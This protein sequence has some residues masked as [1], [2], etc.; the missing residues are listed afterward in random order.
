MG[1]AGGS[2]TDPAADPRVAAAPPGAVPELDELAGEWLPAGTLLNLPSVNNF[3][4]GLHAGSNLLSFTE[5]TFPPL[6]LGGECARLTLAGVAVQAH[7]SRW[8]PYQVLRRA[9]QGG[10]VL[11]SA[12]RMG[13]EQQLVLAELSVTN[14]GT[15][16]VQASLAVELGGYLRSYP[17]LW[18]WQVPRQYGDFSGWDG[19]LADGGRVLAVADGGSPAV[20][21]FAFPDPPGQLTASGKAGSASWQLT[22][23]PGQTATLRLVMAAAATAGD[24]VA[25]AAAARD[26]FAGVWA[27]AQTGWQ[28]RFTDAFT[29]GNRHF[30]GSLPVLATS[31]QALRRLY[32]ASVLTVLQLERTCYP[33]YFPRVYTTAGPQWGVTLSY[34]WDTSLFAPL[35]VML[36]PHM[37]REQAKR[38]LELGI[39]RGYAVDVLSGQL[40]GPWY[41]ANDLSVFSMLFDY[42]TV[43]GDVGFL[44]EQAGGTSV[45]DHMQAIALHWQQLEV[46][47]TGLADYGGQANLLEEVANYVNQV[48][49]LNGA[50]VWMMRQLAALRRAR[51]ETGGAQQLLALAGQL[52]PR[53]LAQY[54][55]G[56]GVWRSVHD[57]GSAVPVRHIYD[58][59]T[60]GRLL[61]GDLPA[62][63]R[64]EMASFVAG[65]LLA[66]GWLRA[67]SLSDPDAPA[68]LRPDHGSNGAYDAWP[69]LAAGTLG[70]LGFYQQ[71][72]EF[73]HTFAAVT[74]EGPFA[75]SHELVPEPSGL[76][77]WD[78]DDL[79][80]VAALTVAAWI[81][82]GAWPRQA[83]QGSIVAKDATAG[84]W[85]PTTP[86]NVGYALRGGGNGVISFAVAVGGKFPQA[87]STATVPA[88]SWHHVAGTF[89]GQRITVYI[90]GGQAATA[91]ARGGISPSAG[92]NLLVGADPIDAA[93]KFTGAI[94]EVRVYQRALPAA[95]IAAL[96]TATDAG[97]GSTDP[98]LTLRLPMD[99][100]SGQHTV[101]AVTGLTETVIAAEWVPGR[102]GAALEFT[103]SSALTTRISRQ[104]YNQNNGGAFAAAVLQDLFGYAPGGQQIA[105]RDPGSPR[106]V[107]ATV[108]G[109]TW[110]GKRYTLASTD[111][112]VSLTPEP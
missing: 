14:P 88:G 52:A 50:N 15:A 26:G 95:E 68:S 8:Y 89:D 59:D 77:V 27:Q 47:A 46:A 107:A 23:L 29:P 9:E 6:S 103:R 7:D 78:R 96:S 100:G 105:V 60:L 25:A 11:Q 17:G 63:Q 54:V 58:F 56:Q 84:V 101:D 30:S 55:T 39:Y 34:F 36:D 75:Q 20:T 1:R 4:G 53:V 98:A 10:L 104:Q 92:T 31:D 22:I 94:D 111:A 67:L 44:D 13:F 86:P 81:N 90:D 110:R 57:D 87:V 64:H 2:G 93:A 21:A 70:R 49:S 85:Y 108:H 69:A 43:T 38:W 61:P 48:P 40:C 32:Y 74:A 91:T 16:P 51:G 18:P 99:E 37:A 62:R 71:M 5:L 109:L 41:S 97:D 72:L 65:E 112:G 102:F 12:L 45:I 19:Q 76:V 28:Q 24:A 80:P 33:Q 79:N 66:G 83:T 82:P 42:V 106:G 35:L 3:S 73:L